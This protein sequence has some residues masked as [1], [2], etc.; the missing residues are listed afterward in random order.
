V[1]IELKFGMEVHYHQKVT[2]IL[3]NGNK[4]AIFEPKWA[5]NPLLYRIESLDYWGYWIE[6][7]YRG[8]LSIVGYENI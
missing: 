2:K 8:T 6:I 4:V 7:W 3:Q 1:A 5:P